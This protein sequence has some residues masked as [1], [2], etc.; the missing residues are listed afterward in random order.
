MFDPKRL[1]D[2]SQS[3]ATYV[4]LGA[5][6]V[7]LGGL[8]VNLGGFFAPSAMQAIGGLLR[9]PGRALIVGGFFAAGLAGDLLPSSLRITCIAVGTALFL[10]YLVPFDVPGLLPF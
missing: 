2:L 5:V 10:R 4:I 7:I 8:V 3:Y 9:S 1:L 6:A